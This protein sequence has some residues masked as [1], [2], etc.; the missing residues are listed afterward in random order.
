MNH[1]EKDHTIQLLL[2]TFPTTAVAEAAHNS[3]HQ[4]K[5]TQ[6]LQLIDIALVIHDE[7]N[8]IHIRE[9][10][11]VDAKRGAAFGGLI[12]LLVGLLAGPWGAVVA[13][14]TGAILGSL[15]AYAIDMGIPNHHLQ[16]IGDALKPGTAAVIAIANETWT[17]AVE[18]HLAASGGNVIVTQLKQSIPEDLEEIATQVEQEIAD[19]TNE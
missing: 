13:L 3:L 12:G 9:S 6:D 16:V 18:K 11:D 4:A 7:S 10:E 1:S 2:A 15:A 5:R 19:Q 14:P 17:P 8:K